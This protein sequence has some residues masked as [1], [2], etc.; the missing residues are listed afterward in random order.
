MS[1]QLWKGSFM[2]KCGARSQTDNKAAALS[3]YFNKR[4]I[5]KKALLFNIGGLRFMQA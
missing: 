4:N 2:G 3:Y 1:W 5:A